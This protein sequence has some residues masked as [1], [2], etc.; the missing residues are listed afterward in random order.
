MLSMSL[1]RPS[2]RQ[3]LENH[4]G[5]LTLILTLL[6]SLS[7]IGLSVFDAAHSPEMLIISIIAIWVTSSIAL[8]YQLIRKTTIVNSIVAISGNAIQTEKYFHSKNKRNLVKIS[9]LL[10]TLISTYSIVQVNNTFTNKPKI[11]GAPVYEIK[12]AEEVNYDNVRF[13]NIDWYKGGSVAIIY[14]GEGRDVPLAYIFNPKGK[15]AACYIEKAACAMKFDAEAN[16]GHE[17]DIKEFRV[18]VL[19]YQPLPEYDKIPIAAF[20]E[21]EV[22]YIQIGKA[23]KYP[24]VFTGVQRV[25]KEGIKQLEGT[26]R[27][28]YGE[29]E[30][31]VYRINA[32]DPGLY[33]IRCEILVEGKEDPIVLMESQDWLFDGEA[34]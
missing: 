2:F 18:V 7:S 34:F 22:I 26:Y 8:I 28:K 23:P 16:F 5:T 4:S 30:T 19:E 3:I 27:L 25:T 24:H 15:Y 17:I 14:D 33:K 9:I 13:T 10:L 20:D 32:K 11:T 12:M 1:S 29:K 31:F 6:A 21:H